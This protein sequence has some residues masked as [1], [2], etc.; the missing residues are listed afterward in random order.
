MDPELNVWNGEKKIIKFS[1]TE[2]LY[3]YGYIEI[4]WVYKAC[5]TLLSLESFSITK[6]YSWSYPKETSK[7]WKP[8]RAEIRTSYLGSMMASLQSWVAY[9]R[10]LK[11]YK[12]PPSQYRKIHFHC[13]MRHFI[14][15]NKLLPHKI[16]K[17]SSGF[18]SWEAWLDSCRRFLFTWEHWSPFG[19]E[20]INGLLSLRSRR[21]LCI[22]FIK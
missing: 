5:L 14:P 20:G 2:C 16:Q 19:I 1:L 6:G 18:N 13:F 8:S 17:Q 3:N 10:A 7:L 11:A 12:V 22:S 9:H 15:V 4:K 21:Y